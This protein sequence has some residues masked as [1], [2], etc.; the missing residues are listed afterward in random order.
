MKV[1][2]YI[3]KALLPWIAFATIFSSMAFFIL[4]FCRSAL[5]LVPGVSGL[6][7]PLF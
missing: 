6:Y 5:N 7:K 2:V 3:R 1:S 4:I